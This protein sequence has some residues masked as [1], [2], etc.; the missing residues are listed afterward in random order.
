M[1]IK[2]RLLKLNKTQ[3][4]LIPELE[5]RFSLYVTPDVLSRIIR[6]KRSSLSCDA[7]LAAVYEILKRWEKDAEGGDAK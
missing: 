5:A 3:R 2:M 7:V 6:G 1:D 4:E